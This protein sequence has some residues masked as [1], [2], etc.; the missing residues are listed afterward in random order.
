[1][2]RDELVEEGA[3]VLAL[4]VLVVVLVACAWWGYRVDYILTHATV[5][6]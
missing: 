1:M 4:V 3:V 6:P 5:T 2:R